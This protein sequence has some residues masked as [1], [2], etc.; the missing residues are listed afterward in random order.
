MVD[1]LI[2]AKRS[3]RLFLLD[4][5]IPGQVRSVRGEENAGSWGRRPANFTLLD[6][7]SFC[8]EHGQQH[9][10]THHD[11]HQPTPRPSRRGC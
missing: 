8:S 7:T 5:L 2:V 6:F 11:R 4:V 10:Y 9:P 1:K 3:H